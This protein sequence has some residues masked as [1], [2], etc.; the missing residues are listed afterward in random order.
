MMVITG[1]AAYY[2]SGIH[3]CSTT[4]RLGCFCDT[5]SFFNNAFV[6][7]SMITFGSKVHYRYECTVYSIKIAK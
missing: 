7:I 5:V 3:T 1:C 4:C 2:Y 6:A